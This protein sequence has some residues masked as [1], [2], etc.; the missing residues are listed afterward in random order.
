MAKTK[1]KLTDQQIKN[2]ENY[3]DQI[4]TLEDFVTAV[5]QMPG[6]YIG[7]K[8]NAG[9]LTMI[10]EIFQN[11]DDELKKKESPCDT[12]IV[13]FDE[14]TLTVIVED[15]G[16]GIPFDNIIRIFENEHTSS[17]YNK[18]QG[19]Y[20]SGLHGVGA[21]ATNALS[22]KFIV[23]S[24]NCII[25]EA[26]RV[27]FNDGY[28]W[29]YGEKKIPNKEGKQGTRI[30]FTPA[31][32]VMGDITVTWQDVRHLISMILPLSEIGATVYFNAI[33]S[34]GRSYQEKMVN[35]D[36][37]LSFIYDTTEAPVVLPIR[38]FKD[39]GFMKMDIAFTYDTS[40]MDSDT[41]IAFANSCPTSAGTH[42]NGFKDGISSFF[43]NYMN[44]VFLANS[45][46]KKSSIKVTAADTRMGLRAIVSVAHLKPIFNGQAKE[47]F[48]NEDMG[49]FVK[50][51]T[52][53]CLDKWSK[54]NPKDFA[55]ICKYLKDVAE[56]RLKQ[57]KEKVNISNK[58]SRSI[59]NGLP[60]KYIQPK[61]KKDLELWIVEGDSAAG[62]IKNHRDNATQ[63]YFPI[64]G[65]IPNAFNTTKEKFLS[66]EEVAGIISIIGGGYGKSFD[67]SK[68]KWKYIIFGADADADGYHISSLLL[69][70][71]LL[72]MPQLIEDGR[73]YRANPPL[74]GL[75]GSKKNIYF[76][77]RLDYIKYVQKLFAKDYAVSHVDGTPVSS[78]ELTK[79]LYT[80]EDYTYELNKISNI[81]AIDPCLLE[82]IISILIVNGN[83]YKTIKS[84]V[85]KKYRFIKVSQVNGVTKLE[86]SYN[87]KIQLLFIIDKFLSECSRIINIIKKNETIQY[88]INGELYTIYQMMVLFEKS[89]PK[90]ISRYKGLGEMIP[91]TLYESTLDKNN[92]HLIRYTVE[93]AKKEKMRYLNNNKGLL[94]ENHEAI[95]RFDIIG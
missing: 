81:Y 84:K 19:E 79:I 64:K 22:K 9:F 45:S 93:D 80:N 13:S 49:S 2:I 50:N 18:K 52:V 48:A 42:I 61:G 67:I 86:G 7:S 46:G 57:D 62:S 28:P 15:N 41:I 74:Y 59:L 72:Y 36:G 17:N 34:N 47:I 82:Y 32:D 24:Y 35:E 91:E 27:E 16:R 73:V 58:Y 63:G 3:A 90:N 56:I 12:I 95:S 31:L 30:T 66:N 85:E 37:I 39:T 26:R 94:L 88:R 43:T 51:T 38:M 8:G 40:S 70:F 87:G 92:R 6:M 25:G 65:K 54:D 23:E 89:T 60:D 68:V 55:K 83:T 69:R 10:R 33:D 53:E 1:M 71:F 75:E 44:K 77:T 76:T 11:S 5:R 78:S 20:S 21:K 4:E 29:K 14:R